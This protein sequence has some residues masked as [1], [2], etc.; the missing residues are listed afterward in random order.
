MFTTINDIVKNKLILDDQSVWATKNQKQFDYSD[1]TSSEKYLETVFKSAKDL[2]ANSYELEKWIKD[3]PS[4]YHLSRK[5]SQLLSGFS[6]DQNARVLEVG[7]GCGAITR[8]LGETFKS[9]VSVEGSI[10]RAHLARQ[11]VSDLDNVTVINSPFQDLVFTKKFD[12]IFCIGVFEYSH[13]FVSGTDPYD[14]VLSN[15]QK[16]ITPSGS[17]VMAIENQFGMKYFASSREDHVNKMHEG[18]E[19]YPNNHSGVRTFGREELKNRLAKHFKHIN[20]YYPYP[21]YKMPTCVLNEQMLCSGTAGELISQ[22]TSRDYA[23]QKHKLFDEGFATLEL[24]KNKQLPFF[25]NSF[26][27]VASN[28]EIS[29]RT[30]NQ[31]GIL[32]SSNRKPKYQTKTK[33]IERKDAGIFS[34]K[35]LINNQEPADNSKLSIH[36]TENSW[37][38]RHSLQTTIRLACKDRGS[39]IETLFRPCKQW[40]VALENIAVMDRGKKMLPGKYVDHIWRNTYPCDVGVDFIDEEWS[41]SEDIKLNVLLIRSIYWCLKDTECIDGIISEL[42]IDNAKRL[43]KTIAKSLGITLSNSDFTSFIQLESEISSAVFG[44]NK[45]NSKRTLNLYMFSRRTLK[46]LRFCKVMLS[47]VVSKC[48]RVINKIC[49]S[50]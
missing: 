16:H 38:G 17:V 15:F 44:T 6:F 28:S 24:D 39:S 20:F 7:C 50:K 21:D 23:G 12:I 29:D 22:I 37:V 45:N 32:F 47:N 30:F 8:Y 10:T 11:R 49:L 48:K 36:E 18:I 46:F 43:I 13:L 25:A 35:T 42:C 19:G 3:W 40:I 41:W 31:L 2:T 14:E 4:E 9:V 34:E 26:L 33:I 1:G 5:R 27:V